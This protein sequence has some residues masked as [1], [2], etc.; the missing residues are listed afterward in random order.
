MKGLAIKLLLMASRCFADKSL[1]MPRNFRSC[2]RRFD[3]G[4]VPGDLKSVVQEKKYA[5]N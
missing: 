1:I 2:A 4:V 5:E 3:L